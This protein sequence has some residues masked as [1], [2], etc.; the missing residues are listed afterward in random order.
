M[1]MSDEFAARLLPLLEDAVIHYGTPFHVYDGRGI[2][3][4]HHALTS[5]FSDVPFRQYFAIKSLPNPNIL[6]LLLGAGSGIDCSS[7]VE[8]ELARCV[9][10]TGHDI[11]FTSNN[12]SV[13]EYQLAL[14]TGA[15]VTFDDQTFLSKADPLPEVV[16]F[17]VSPWGEAAGSALMGDTTRSKFGVPAADLAGAYREARRRGASRFGIHGMICANELDL[18][19]AIQAAEDVIAQAARVAAEIAIEFEYI[20]IGGGLGIPYRPG[21]NPLNFDAYAAAIIEARNRWHG[22]DGPQIITECGRCIT[23][24]HG[25][26][27]SSVITRCRK[28]CDIVGL[29]ASMSALMRPAVYGAYHHI[30]LPFADGRPLSAFDVVGS[31]CENMDKFAM[32]RPLPDPREG[33]IVLIHDTGAHGHSMGFTYN[34]RLRPAELLLTDDDEL[35]QI[36]RA[37]TFEDYVATVRLPIAPAAPRHHRAGSVT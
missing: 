26:L 34:G 35:V 3:K 11:V 32:D 13:A 19:R 15:L 25:V 21:E 31:L 17:R 23:G 12:T 2:I 7:A 10:A 9:G 1:P 6:T 16:S 14:S 4:T 30:S 20:N 24:P 33:D 36:R 27:V 29:D 18:G 22:T 8:L 37:E 28:G 5:A